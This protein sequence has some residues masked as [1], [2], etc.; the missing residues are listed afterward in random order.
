MKFCRRKIAWFTFW[1][2]GGWRNSR[3][4]PRSRRTSIFKKSLSHFVFKSTRDEEKVRRSESEWHFVTIFEA[5]R[6][7]ARNSIM[8][9][10]HRLHFI[11]FFIAQQRKRAWKC[12][13]RSFRLPQQHNHKQFH[14]TWDYAISGSH[15]STLFFSLLLIDFIYFPIKLPNLTFPRTNVE[16]KKNKS[17]FFLACFE[18]L[19]MFMWANLFLAIPA[20]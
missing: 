3:I 1:V 7:F 15:Y 16:E 14:S 12:R 20:A 10:C 6:E 2:N 19:I 11:A 9:N 5:V 4:T 18:N 17:L 8:W 13:T